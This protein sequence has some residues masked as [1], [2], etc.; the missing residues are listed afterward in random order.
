VGYGTEG[1]V[2]ALVGSLGPVRPAILDD[3]EAIAEALATDLG[4]GSILTKEYIRTCITSGKVFVVPVRDGTA[5]ERVVAAIIL[6]PVFQSCQIHALGC[7][8]DF[9]RKGIGTTLVEAAEE[10]CRQEKIPKL[11]CWSLV[12]YEKAEWYRRRGFSEI[13]LL[14]KQFFNEDCYF[15]GKLLHAAG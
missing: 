10:F 3:A 12:R 2:D 4:F 6:K 7:R 11:W 1:K 9:Q 5:S 14:G 8:S 15:C 13:V